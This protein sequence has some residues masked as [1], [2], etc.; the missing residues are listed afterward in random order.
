[1]KKRQD[2]RSRQKSGG[3]Y[4]NN[5]FVVCIGNAGRSAFYTH[6]LIIPIIWGKWVK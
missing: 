5:N 3:S 2:R 1:M 6:F 4:E